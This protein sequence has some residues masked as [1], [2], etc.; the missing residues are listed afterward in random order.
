MSK[1][2]Q[3]KK[4]LEKASREA[5]ELKQPEKVATGSSTPEKPASTAIKRKLTDE[6]KAKII[7]D[8]LANRPVIVFRYRN[9]QLNKRLIF[10]LALMVIALGVA[11]YF[12][13]R[14]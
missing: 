14:M 5:K 2:S 12:L 3:I 7:R 11:L 4:R 6:E 8:R 1:E 9:G 10:M 13:S